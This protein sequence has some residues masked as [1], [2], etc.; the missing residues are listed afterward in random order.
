VNLGSGDNFGIE[1]TFERYLNKNYYFLL[2]SS[3]FN[4]TY[5]GYDKRSRNSAFD[6]NYAFNAVGGYELVMGKR[7]WGVMSF[8]LRATW[9]GGNPYIPF[10]VN[11]TLTTGEAVPDWQQ[12]YQVRYPDYKRISVRFGIKRNLPGY[13]L[14]FMLD[15]Q[16]RTNYTNVY[17][18]RI[19]PKTGEIRY[20][21]N[22][23]F[24]PMATWRIQF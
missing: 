14:E 3:L 4:S 8:G 13:N 12:A 20:F 18:Q 23:G 16:Y 1:F 5:C 7:K 21:F 19:D 22:M 10:D 9:A 6:V 24:F 11:A 2:S 15:L 17:L